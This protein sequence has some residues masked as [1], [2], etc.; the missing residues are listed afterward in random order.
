MSKIRQIVN[1][2]IIQEMKGRLN[3]G[4]KINT[5]D[6]KKFGINVDNI[7]NDGKFH[8]LGNKKIDPSK[9]G[10]FGLAFETIEVD[11]RAGSGQGFSQ[12]ELN[13]S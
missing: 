10:L 2:I 9:L 4:K 6:L 11:I 3:E 8:D 5:A 7:P 1:K 12:V 13:F